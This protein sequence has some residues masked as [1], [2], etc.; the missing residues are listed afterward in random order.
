MGTVGVTKVFNGFLLSSGTNTTT[1]QVLNVSDATG[2]F[3]FVVKSTAG[4]TGAGSS[5]I[6]PYISHDGTNW[7]VGTATVVTLY[8]SGHASAYQFVSYNAQL[9]VCKY[10]KWT[11]TQAGSDSITF[12]AWMLQDEGN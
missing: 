9:P 11:A 2:E 8:S 7:T 4:V 3:S 6:K 12:S 1:S 5:N 10:V